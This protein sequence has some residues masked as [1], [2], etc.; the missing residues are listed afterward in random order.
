MADSRPVRSAEHNEVI[1]KFARKYKNE[2]E[3]SKA[4]TKYVMSI[5]NKAERI[6]RLPSTVY[7][8]VHVRP[9]AS[10]GGFAE[11][12]EEIQDMIE[13]Y[14][15]S[16]GLMIY[17]CA[18][19]LVYSSINKLMYSGEE[20]SSGTVGLYI[21]LLN[22]AILHRREK[23]EAQNKPIDTVC[24]LPS[25]DPKAIA[26]YRAVA[27]AQGDAGCIYL[28]CFTSATI[29]WEVAKK[30]A[31]SKGWVWIMEG[32]SNSSSHADITPKSAYAT[33]AEVLLCPNMCFRV[34]GLDER[35]QILFL[36]FEHEED[37][38]EE[39]YAETME[40]DDPDDIDR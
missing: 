33:E 35:K 24:G 26:Q 6:S 15:L 37:G 10:V 9:S 34:Q 1:D 30:F 11:N 13:E 2:R 12:A 5:S 3:A 21:L 19:N 39:K 32:L 36:K 20:V 38:L 28:P 31:G 22:D 40:G 8:N 4:L 17:L 27:G 16:R 7:A 18:T 25:I 14:F 29:K 23:Y